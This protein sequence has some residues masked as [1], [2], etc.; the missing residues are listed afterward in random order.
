M[1]NKITQ[2]INL[3]MENKTLLKSN[4]TIYY[5]IKLKETLQQIK[6]KLKKN[7]PAMGYLNTTKKNKCR[8]TS[9]YNQF[10]IF[11]NI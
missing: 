5:L 3:Q 1:M 11:K 10:G 9:R 4:K 8:V 2:Q 6:I 7:F